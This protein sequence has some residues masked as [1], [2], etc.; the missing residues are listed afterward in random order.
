MHSKYSLNAH[1]IGSNVFV[2]K[3]GFFNN[4]EINILKNEFINSKL[5]Y[6]VGFQRQFNPSIKLLKNILKSGDLGKISKVFVKVS[7]FIPSW[8]PYENYK[9]LYACK[10]NL[11]GGILHTECHELFLLS[12]LFG[13][14]K[15]CKKKLFSSYEHE[16]DVSDSCELEIGY[17]DFKVYCDIS[18][19]REPNERVLEFEMELG[20]IKL[21][22]NSNKIII[23]KNKN[24]IEEKKFNFSSDF[25]FEL[26]AKSVLKLEYDNKITFSRL[27]AL[28]EIIN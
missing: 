3:P 8:H 14:H 10:K 22:L 15:Y 2:E 4:E 24:L 11:G 26:Q 16:L 9:E 20:T 27:E 19:M 17:D 12:S 13:C 25:L 6:M 1:K 5:K 18:F 28:G 21:D 23:Y 7:S